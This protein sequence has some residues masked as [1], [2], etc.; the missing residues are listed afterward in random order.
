MA[1]SAPIAFSRSILASED[2]VAITLAPTER[3]NCR[4]KIETPPVP[5]TSTLWPAFSGRPAT[6]R[7]FQAV[8]A[9]QGR[10]AASSKLR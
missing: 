8:R 7:A 1:A 2:E 5:S 9:A 6:K 3:A 10:Q 4:A